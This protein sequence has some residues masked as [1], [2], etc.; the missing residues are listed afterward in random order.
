MTAA[1]EVC[2]ARVYFRCSTCTLGE[3]ALDERLGV[4]GRYSPH[5]QRLICLAGASWSF[6]VASARLEELCGLCVSDTTI[7]EVSQVHGAQM[8]AWQRDCPQA[9]Q[10][11]R[12]ADGDHEFTTDGASV[13]TTS[14]W[15]EMKLAI[16]SRRRRG[17]AAT[18]HEWETRSLPAPHV[19]VAF[20]AIE[21][22][23]RFGTRWKQWTRRLGIL[24]PSV[25]TLLADGA[26]W[27]WEEKLTNLRG[28][29]GVLDIYHALQHVCQTANQLHGEGCPEAADWAR[30]ARE[31][32]LARGWN[33]IKDLLEQTR[34]CRPDDSARRALEALENYLGHHIDHLCYAERLAKGQSIGSGQ[35]EG[36]CKN[37]IARR[38]KQTGAR[39]RTRRVN[40]MAGLCCLIYSN[41][42]IQYW[43]ALT[44]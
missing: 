33:G 38:L 2:L 34:R 44:A 15:R 41:N 30:K 16:F 21:R 22:S 20:A 14:G 36:A 27:I 3:F 39:W 29:E 28:A 8:L 23:D 13:N 37:L 17:A 6:D 18:P 35:V 5:A 25:V 10:A 19:R 32:L 42:W 1:G 43:N 11:F 31:L 40:R 4:Q 26:K 9:A 24:D 12:E 7:R